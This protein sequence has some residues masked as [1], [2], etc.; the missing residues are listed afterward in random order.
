MTV[1]HHLS[2][3]QQCTENSKLHSYLKSHYASGA[4]NTKICYAAEYS[5]FCM[6]DSGIVMSH[7]LFLCSL[8]YLSIM[9]TQIML[10][11]EHVH[12]WP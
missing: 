11:C 4:H 2:M 10:L 5:S 6:L 12:M 8:H 7:V 9:T 3:S 1:N